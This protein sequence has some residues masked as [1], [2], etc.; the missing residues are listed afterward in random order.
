MPVV[1]SSKSKK[2]NK[3]LDADEGLIEKSLKRFK[4]TAESESESR[5][6]GLEDLR[7]SIGTGQWD[8]AVKAN[9]EIEGKPCLTINRAPAFLRQYTGEERQHRPSM[10]V[11]P[12][13]SGAD[14]ETAKI[15]QGVLRHIEVVSVADVTYDNSYD[16]MMRIG[17]CPWR[18]KTDYVHERSF[19]QEPRIEAIE[20]PFSAYLSPVRRPDGTDPLWGHIVNDYSWEEYDAEFGDSE[21]S[22][23]KNTA[24]YSSR[25]RSVRLHFPTSQGNAEPEW[26][27]KDGCRVA[28]YWWIELIPARLCQLD[29]GHTMLRSEIDKADKAE[30]GDPQHGGVVLADHI[31]DERDTVIRKVNCV[32]H[33]ALQVLKRYDYLG[34]YLPFPEVNGVRLNVDGKVYRAGMVRDYRDAQRIYDFMVTRAVEQVDQVSKDPLWVSDANA[35][36]GEDYRQ[37]NRKNFSHVF[38]KA[39]DENGRQLPVPQRAGRE[40][41]IEAM[42]KIIQQAD[43]DMKAVIGIYGSSLGEEAGSAQESGFAI[44]QRKNQSDTGAVTWHD[45]LNRAIMWQGKILLDLWPKLINSARVQRIVNPDDS[46]KHGVVFNSKNTD[47][48]EA[49]A[50]L[51]AAMGMKK[52]YDVGVGDYD[53][54]LSTGPMYADARK[55]AFAALTAVIQEDPQAL[56]P[57]LG[58]IWAKNADFSDADV[59]AARFKKMLPPN[60]QD[61]SAEDAQSKLQQAQAQI[62]TLTEQYNIVLQE[63]T[64]AADTIRTK[65]IEVESRERIALSNNQTQLLLQQMKDHSAAAQAQLQAKLDAITERLSMLHQSMTIDQDAGEAP[66]TPELPGQVEPKVQP[67]TPAAP[68]PRPQPIGPTQ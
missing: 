34:R 38:Y 29:T 15:H 57:M 49:Q 26:I 30:D 7:F 12:V 64:R 16:M 67:I 45:N 42:S 53:L 41:P 31:V 18:V 56:L 48:A 22:K 20:N 59:V 21:I 4:I 27:T 3:K 54:V 25:Y 17:W 44:M 66:N 52:A 36:Y 1:L 47:P 2:R 14:V 19:D 50:L 32:K 46:V 63:M 35:Q 23:L 13:G 40:A 60:L 68:T 51:N 62:Q 28:E 5:R 39:Y 8:E 37:I 24:N 65:R 10:L 58:D 11:S 33:D 6:Q 55:E 43:Y 61:E 9:R